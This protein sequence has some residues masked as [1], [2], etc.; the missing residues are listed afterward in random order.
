MA[1]KT[2]EQLSEEIAVTANELKGL[3]G[4]RD[5]EITKNGKATKETAEKLDAV[6]ETLEAI[7]GDATKAQEQTDAFKKRLDDI[8]AEKNRPGMPKFNVDD[9]KSAGQLYTES[10]KYK[11]M[12]ESG[13]KNG[14]RVI[15]KSLL[16]RKDTYG[17]VTLTGDSDANA[18]V[19]P[20]RVPEIIMPASRALNI[21]DLI[22][23]APTSSGSIE[24]TEE[25]G[26]APLYTELDVAATAG[27]KT[28]STKAIGG[29]FAGQ[30]VFISDEQFTV[31]SVDTDAN[32]FTVAGAYGITV[33][34]PKG[35]PVVSNVFAPT[36]EGRRKPQMNVKYELKTL[37]TKTIADWIP[38]S[39]QA[40]ADAGQL[41]S[42]INGR[43]M[44]ALG[45]SEEYQVLYG[46]G[47]GQEI[48]GIMTHSKVQTYK[49]SSGTTG[50]TRIDAVRRAMTLARLAE[51]PIDT[52]VLH[53]TDWEHIELAKGT[54]KRYI[55]VQVTTGGVMQL[56]KAP[57]VDT[58]A[59]SA[60][61]FLTGALK[62][63]A[64]LYDQ[65]VA[66][67]DVAEQHA[68]FFIENMVAVRAE[69]RVALAIFR[70]EAFVVGEFDSA[71]V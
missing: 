10:E 30:I 42:L 23:V 13:S 66:A 53:P 4:N 65:E 46:S 71:P 59:I 5:D 22:T 67:I 11:Q 36:A 48:Q 41:Q 40:L 58:T 2:F 16:G 63:G 33:D 20:Y 6:G 47:T 1:E 54:N 34:M 44:Y 69:E 14:E 50:D 24:Y 25:T 15:L 19:V 37:A 8:E 64:T 7:A 43:L 38:V 62:M 26:F 39:R 51:Y 45:L 60:G 29:C 12:I 35:T 31:A 32:D 55:W 70:P 49:W 3:I 9:A 57:V 28:F 21:R 17:A 18:L 27:D 56:W 68:E 52:V 61:E